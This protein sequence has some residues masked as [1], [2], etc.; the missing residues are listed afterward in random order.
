MKEKKV[1]VAIYGSGIAGLTAAVTLLEHGVRDVCVFEK[2]PFQGG[3]I[4][5]T[6][7]CFLA[8]K[9]MRDIRTELLK[10]MQNIHSFPVIWLLRGHGSTTVIGFRHL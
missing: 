8:V 10:S 5:N 9:T 1:N 2:R 4:S 3:A 6:P 7:M